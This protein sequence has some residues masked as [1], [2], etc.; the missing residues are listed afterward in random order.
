MFWESSHFG[1]FHLGKS[2]GCYGD[3]EFVFSE[4]VDPID[5]IECVAHIVFYFLI[6]KADM[7]GAHRMFIFLQNMQFI[8]VFGVFKKTLGSSWSFFFAFL[9]TFKKKR[10]ESSLPFNQHNPCQ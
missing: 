8:D 10:C 5:H 3:L 1:K 2:L 7:P 9:V 4:P 6:K